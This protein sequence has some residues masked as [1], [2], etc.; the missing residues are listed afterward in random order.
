MS[1]SAAIIVWDPREPAPLDEIA[2]SVSELTDGKI[3]IRQYP[4]DISDYSIIIADHPVG[5]E[6]AERMWVTRGD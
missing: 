1:K 4:T 2:E 5:D 3:T 6:E